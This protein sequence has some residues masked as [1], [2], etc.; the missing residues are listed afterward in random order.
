MADKPIGDL[1]P[2]TAFTKSD[3]LVMEQNGQ[4]K[5]VTGQV[6]MR[7]LAK[8]LDGHGGINNIALKSSEGLVD[9]YEITTADG[10][11][12]EY[13]VTNGFTP[14]ISLGES[15]HPDGRPGVQIRVEGQD[16]I[17]Q[18]EIYDGD[19]GP[20]GT[21]K[22][23]MDNSYFLNVVNQQEQTRYEG[24]GNAIDRWESPAGGLMT[25]EYGKVKD[26]VGT[27][28]QMVTDY[29]FMGIPITMAAKFADGSMAVGSA[30]LSQNLTYIA[31]YTR[32]DGV[33]E[34]VEAAITGQGFI[35]ISI[36]SV[37]GNPPVWAALYIGEYTKETLPEY[38]YKGYAAELME[39]RRY[40]IAPDAVSV[41]VEILPDGEAVTTAV[42][43]T[44]EKR[45]IA[46]GI[47]DRKLGAVLYTEQTLTEEQKAQA[48]ENIGVSGGNV[49][50]SGGGLSATASA[51]LINILRNAVYTADQS[52]S[53]TALESALLSGGSGGGTDEPD[54]PVEPDEPVVTTYTIVS[55]LLHA[56]SN[57]ASASVESGAS[58]TATITADDG[59]TLDGATVSVSMG[60]VDITATAYANGVVTIGS[61]TGNVIITVNAVALVASDILYQLASPMTF[62][63]TNGIDTGVML[64]DE[65]KDFSILIDLTGTATETDFRSKCLI[66][67]RNVTAGSSNEGFDIRTSSSNYH[68]SFG[69]YANNTRFGLETDTYTSEIVSVKI[70]MTHVKGS[71]E[72]VYSLRDVGASGTVKTTT[73]TDSTV[74]SKPH[75]GT[76]GL[77]TT[78][79][80]N[81]AGVPCTVH[82]FAIYNRVISNEEITAF[83]A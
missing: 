9:T 3:L 78:L 64:H 33:G 40:Y 23:W 14:R 52:A 62:D 19:P 46:L 65:D 11:K 25:I 63:G 72:I 58:Y 39:C 57:N 18:A 45:H 5:S 35:Q 60:G 2:A 75:S 24:T 30:A 31:A 69:G 8:M 66:N 53:I 50:Q 76:F 10:T 67:S 70:V 61:V 32:P 55:A 26:W 13:A 81:F 12:F 79:Q 36:Y 51:L 1:T 34:R 82:E 43:G 16:G 21:P 42:S 20:S 54:T 44:L 56:T 73:I 6:L 17:Q 41:D 38:Q 37:G 28:A 71:N 29:N 48:R 47:P 59:Y 27:Y 4:A 74:F 49:D 80:S 15:L 77:C 68:H 22:N 83:F 7:D